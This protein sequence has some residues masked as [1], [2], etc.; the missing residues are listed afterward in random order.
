[1]EQRKTVY[2]ELVFGYHWK[3]GTGDT[4]CKW[5]MYMEL[6]GDDEAVTYIKDVGFNA[7]RPDM[8]I[9][10]MTKVKQQLSQEPKVLAAVAAALP[11]G[12]GAC[13]ANNLPRF[14][15]A[16]GDEASTYAAAVRRSPGHSDGS[17]WSANSRGPSPTGS[18]TPKLRSLHLGSRGSSPSS[19]ISE[20]TWDRDWEQQQRRLSVGA[21]HDYR[22]NSGFY[23]GR[24][25]GAGERRAS[26]QGQGQSKASKGFQAWGRPRSNSYT[27]PQVR[28]P[29]VI[30]GL[31]SVSALEREEGKA[32]EGGWIEVGRPKR[33]TARP[34]EKQVR[35]RGK[36]GG[37]GGGGG[38]RGGGGGGRG[39][40]GG[41]RGGGGGGGRGGGGGGG[42][43]SGRT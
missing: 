32:S 42:R 23:G 14:L 13:A 3:P 31:Q 18:L 8:D 19:T 30:P 41:G 24:G 2:L 5:K 40:G 4:D 22:R 39:G 12:G 27:Q 37:G 7:N 35:G 11:P 38:G 25:G 6:D 1:M 15:T 34:E 28:V 29:R 33:T 16:Y 20:S 26:V 9:L 21:V 10:K 36:R 43:G 17:P